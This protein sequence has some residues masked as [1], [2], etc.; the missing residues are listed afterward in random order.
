MLAITKSVSMLAATVAAAL[1]AAPAALADPPAH[2]PAH[3]WRAKHQ[4]DYAG[5]D[6][7]RWSRDYG[8]H[9][10][11]CD[12]SEVATVLGAVVGGAIGSSVGDGDGRLIAILAGATLGAVVGRE[13][14]RDMDGSDR[15]CLGHSLELAPAGHRV[16]WTGADPRVAYAITPHAAFQRGQLLCREFD[17]VR[18]DRDRH[19]RKRSTACRYGDGDWRL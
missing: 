18:H 7:H 16:E 8:V 2:A 12:R 9:S 5:Y 1:L 10:G 17:L 13:I 11:R 4:P 3:G 15:A 6:Q 19:A 14:G